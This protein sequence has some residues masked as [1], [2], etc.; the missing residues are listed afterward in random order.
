MFPVIPKYISHIHTIN[1]NPISVHSEIQKNIQVNF[2]KIMTLKSKNIQIT[3]T[4]IVLFEKIMLDELNHDL[5]ITP[6]PNK[7]SIKQTL[8]SCR[9]E[10][11]KLNAQRDQNS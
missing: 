11:M 5:L 3:M 2:K 7:P 10:A 1:G 4:D 9:S 8:E 6:T